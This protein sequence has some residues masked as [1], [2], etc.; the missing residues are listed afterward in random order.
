MDV[1]LHVVIF[2]RRPF[3]LQALSNKGHR[4]RHGLHI[5]RSLQCASL[6]ANP[7]N[8]LHHALLHHD[9]EADQGKYIHTI[10]SAIHTQMQ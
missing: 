5:F 8:V 9:E 6:L 2:D 4:H 7:C 3:C 1:C 10:L